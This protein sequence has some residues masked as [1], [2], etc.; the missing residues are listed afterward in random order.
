[1]LGPSRLQPEPT[2]ERLALL[3]PG[4]S[5]RSPLRTRDGANARPREEPERLGHAALPDRAVRHRPRVPAGSH[6]LEPHRAQPR[7]PVRAE[8]ALSDLTLAR[9][10]PAVRCSG[11]SEVDTRK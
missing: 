7:P 5:R 9:E 2:L 8:R 4:R 10:S 1:P 11:H 3:R 6:G